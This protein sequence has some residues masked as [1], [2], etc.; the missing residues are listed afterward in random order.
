[1]PSAIVVRVDA[2]LRPLMPRFLENQGKALVNL[3]E[4]C[5]AQQFDRVR[6]LGHTMKG[7]CGGYGLHELTEL[8]ARLEEAAKIGNR[9][10]IETLLSAVSDYLERLEIVFDA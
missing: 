1:M 8:G 5:D 7:V 10:A 2:E 3:R 4:A 9:G 6:E